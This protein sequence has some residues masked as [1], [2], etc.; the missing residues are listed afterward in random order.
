MYADLKRTQ[1]LVRSPTELSSV[2]R[3]W[4]VI[5]GIIARSLRV[6]T[7]LQKKNTQ[8][9]QISGYINTMSSTQGVSVS[10]TEFG[11]RTK[12]KDSP[13]EIGQLESQNQS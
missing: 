10:A 7:I 2:S 8:K 11:I 1:Q 12:K 3:G 9:K 4:S 5:T 13:K 6:W